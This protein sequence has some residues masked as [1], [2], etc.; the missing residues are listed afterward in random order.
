V[1]NQGRLR[2]TIEGAIAYL[3]T[4]WILIQL[5]NVLEE[6]LELPQW[7]DRWATIGIFAGFPVVI[8]LIW[9]FNI[10]LGSFRP[11]P[12]SAGATE[13]PI[14]R[15]DVTNVP[16]PDK[17][18]I[19][20]LPFVDMSQEHDQE[21]FG[22]G[23]SEEIL[24]A[25]VKVKALKVAG[26]TSSFQYKGRNE[27]LSDIGAALGVA[28]VL[29]GSVRKQN[30]KV[31]ITAQLI[32]ADN[33]Y[34]LWSETYDGDLSDIFDLQDSIAK[35]IVEELEVLLGAAAP[36]RLAT[37]LT[38]SPE[39]YEYFLQG[40]QL[41][42]QQVGQETL[43]RAV[44]LLEK[45]V[46][47]DPHFAEAWAWLADANYT[48]TENS[49]TPNWK[50]HILAA[51]Q[52]CQRAID[53]DPQLPMAYHALAYR[54]SHDKKLDEVMDIYEKA[55]KLDNTNAELVFAYGQALAGI[56]QLSSAKEMLAVLDKE[57]LIAV[58]HTTRANGLYAT[59]DIKQAAASY[60][61]SIDLGFTMAAVLYGYMLSINSNL[62]EALE[63]VDRNWDRFP[64]LL[65]RCLVLPFTRSIFYAAIF[66]RWTIARWTALLVMK[67]WA[68]LPNAQPNSVYP[69]AYYTLGGAK[70]FLDYFSHQPCPYT[71]GN[72]VVLWQPT[73]EARRIRTHDAFP[74]FADQMGL[75]RLWQKHGWPEFVQPLPGTDGSNLQFTCS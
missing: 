10:S 41:V 19:A 42:H 38:N 55:W 75:V 70:S 27:N 9:A 22:D 13:P 67:M 25:L 6:S 74:S 23:I 54:A 59:G 24:N 28:H 66:R 45:A 44:E 62:S 20:V 15:P 4:G 40:R 58:F 35:S 71:L 1:F 8:I 50:D 39:A 65:K 68:S 3:V 7:V 57:P 49:A 60:Q 11:Q 43:P 18:S 53:L 30:N 26:R 48:L 52:A 17:Q 29:E 46:A 73:E 2:N 61:R 64:L 51:H 56:G 69:M 33:G 32:Q 16:L 21:Y 63:V 47:L 31:R 14:V 72:L 34:H 37:N 12:R 36:T 5:A